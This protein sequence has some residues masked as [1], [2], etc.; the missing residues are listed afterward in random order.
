PRR[1]RQ[2]ARE[3]GGQGGGG[4]PAARALHAQAG[5]A[6]LPGL[7]RDPGHRRRVDRAEEVRRAGGR[8]RLQEGAGRGRTVQVRLVQP[9]RRLASGG[10]R[11]ALGGFEQYWRKAPSVKTLGLRTIG[12]ESTRLAALKRGEVDMAYSITGPLAEELKR[13]QGLT[14]V[15]T[16]FTF[17]TWLVFPDQWD[18]KSPWPDPRVPFAPNLAIDRAGINAAVYLGLSRLSFSFIPQGMDYFWAP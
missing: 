15:P 14:L 9:G 13:G 18:P 2:P 6:R 16:Y 10:V 12:D 17:T 7:L 11:A 1:Q 3:Q 8:R 5:L 4:R